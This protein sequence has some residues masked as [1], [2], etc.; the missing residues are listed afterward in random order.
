MAIENF[1]KLSEEKQRHILGSALSEFAEYGYDG[2]STNRIIQRAGISKGV[3]F[4]YFT[5]KEE[6]F[7]YVIKTYQERER[8]F[9][10]PYEH[11][12]NIFE[13]MKEALYQEYNCYSK[14]KS[15]K[16]YYFLYAKMMGNL[17]HPVYK[18][19]VDRYDVGPFD[20]ICR[21]IDEADDSFLRKGLTKSAAKCLMFIMIEGIRS[22]FRSNLEKFFDEDQILL[23][24]MFMAIDTIKA[25]MLN[26]SDK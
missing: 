12:N 23:K 2:A 5:S 17:D 21:T 26:E 9:L 22:Y 1:L 4:K 25:G 8:E 16:A 20:S 19:A 6:L 15:L 14:D 11:S 24:E 18:T 7:Y 13:E 3:L 10:T